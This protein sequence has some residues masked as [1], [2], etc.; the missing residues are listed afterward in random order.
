[1]PCATVFLTQGPLSLGP[2]IFQC[3][4]FLLGLEL[5]QHHPACGNDT[6]FF[7]RKGPCPAK[8]ELEAL[9][10]ELEAAEEGPEVVLCHGPRLGCG[11][12]A[13]C[14]DATALSILIGPAREEGNFINRAG[15][16]RC[17]GFFPALVGLDCV[18][19]RDKTAL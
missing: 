14:P 5:Y 16:Q 3:Q 15:G 2:V 4:H 18:T 10:E 19:D 12:G 13:F 7:G 11:K 17:E 6:A 9:D 8:E 1:V